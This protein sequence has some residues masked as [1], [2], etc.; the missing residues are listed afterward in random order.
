[1][2][3]TYGTALALW[4]RTILCHP[5]ASVP[6][7][8]SFRNVLSSPPP[9]PNTQH[10]PGILQLLLHFPGKIQ[11]YTGPYSQETCYFVVF[12]KSVVISSYQHDVTEHRVAPHYIVVCK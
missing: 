5:Y 1:M 3:Q 11:W 7:V 2:Y 6:A 9:T 10:L 8:P 12:L 4:L